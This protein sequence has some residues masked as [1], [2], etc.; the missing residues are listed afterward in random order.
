MRRRIHLNSYR[1][2]R[3]AMHVPK[4]EPFRDMDLPCETL[5]QR[6][7]R[8]IPILFIHAKQLCHFPIS[9]AFSGNVGLHPSAIN[10]ELRNRT[11][12]GALDHFLCGPGCLFNVDLM[13]GNVVLGEPAFCDMAIAAPRGSIDS[14]F[15][16]QI[17]RSDEVGNTKGAVCSA[18]GP[19]E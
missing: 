14:Y 17:S 5:F 4:P 6:D 19:H 13:V 11:L 16:R 12:A 8:G 10:D 3:Q 2:I 9:E 1:L 7:W 15:H 18:D